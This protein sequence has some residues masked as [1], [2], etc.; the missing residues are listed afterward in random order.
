MLFE[1]LSYIA[2][3]ALAKL[4]GWVIRRFYHPAKIASS[5]ELELRN[6]KPIIISFGTDIPS[7]GLYFQIYN[8]SPFDFVLDRL[9]IDFW[10]GQPI[11]HGVVLRR[12]DVP[13]GRR[14]ENVYF[15][16]LFTLPQQ[17]YIKKRIDGQ[18]LSVPV[19]IMLTGYFE[20]KLGVV[21]VEKQLERTDVLCK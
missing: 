1:A 20:S 16:H 4:P 6:N 18:L 3:R 2:K 10:I 11:L 8:N 7:V 5:I 13:H 9:L 19:S 17:E 14:I 15:E 12:Y 21:C